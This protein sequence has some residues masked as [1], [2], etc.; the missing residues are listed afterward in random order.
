MKHSAFMIA[1]PTSDSGKST[2]TI[3]LLR[4]LRNHGVS[5]Q[6]F[7]CGPDYIDPKLHHV[8]CGK[9]SINLDL[10]M[11]G[12]ERVAESFRRYDAM[13]QVSIVEG[14][15]GLYDGYN[16]DLGSTA[17]LARLLSIPIILVITPK[18]MAYSVAPLLYGVK[19]F[20]PQL[21]IVGVVFNK[22]NSE[23]HYKYLLQACEDTGIPCLGKLP[24]D[25]DL[26][27]PSRYLG[28]ETED[29]DRLE[30]F[31][32]QAAQLIEEN[33]SLELIL[34]HTASPQ[35]TLPE[36]PP[37]LSNLKI[38]VA[39][40]EAFS[41]IYPENIT[42]LECF[43]EVTYF[44]P[45]HDSTLP[46]SDLLYL[47]GGYPELYLPLLAQNRG[48]LQE[49]HNYAEVGQALLA[50]GGG[51]LYLNKALTD[52]SNRRY[53]LV[54]LFD[55]EATFRE[56]RLTLGY[57]QLDF[58]G[59]LIRGHE[60]HYSRIVDPLPSDLQQYSAHQIAVPTQTLRHKG[61]LATYTHFAFT[62]QFLQKLLTLQPREQGEA[63][64]N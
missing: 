57:R 9:P 11:Q 35:S 63:L 13:S 7:K 40:D 60:F 12:E 27:L 58:E 5:V 45:I 43:G 46:P 24:T 1:A 2:L 23:S 37:R 15:M 33:L 25:K 19:H 49:I 8:A 10:F 38:S 22:V 52:S 47:P 41:F 44:S 56:A 53:E 42:L 21:N 26:S 64:Q 39:R 20:Q 4:A 3:G 54:G 62:T 51:M 18:S 30:R 6:P 61:V 17:H 34:E 16:R 55:Q 28:L 59:V 32:E 29:R 50:E 14:V 31:A 36:L 48:M